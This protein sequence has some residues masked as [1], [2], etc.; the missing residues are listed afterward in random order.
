MGM[1]LLDESPCICI[2][3]GGAREVFT[4]CTKIML[5]NK[6]TELSTFAIANDALSELL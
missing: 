3:Q 4:S 1:K 5:C 6:T 2:Q